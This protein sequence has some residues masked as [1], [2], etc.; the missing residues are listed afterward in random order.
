M[1]RSFQRGFTLIELLVVIA[2]IAVLA[3]LLIPVVVKSR[4]KA[5]Q[6]RCASRNRRGK[7]SSNPT[8]TTLHPGR[9]NLLA[10][11]LKKMQWSECSCSPWTR[12]NRR[13]LCSRCDIHALTRLEAPAR[14]CHHHYCNPLNFQS[15]GTDHHTRDLTCGPSLARRHLLPPQ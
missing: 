1:S 11:S 3:G 15:N 13:T 2:I 4:A 8:T 10:K 7:R 5:A 12:A 14:L 9:S 6:A